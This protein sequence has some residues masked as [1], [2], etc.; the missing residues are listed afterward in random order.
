[1]SDIIFVSGGSRSG[2]SEFA[3]K[4]VGEFGESIL[5][6]ATGVNT[7]SEMNERIL[8]HKNRRPK[9]WI[10]MEAYK[11]L[12]I[13][14]GKLENAFDATL[15]DCV[16][17]MVT[18]ILFE[19]G[20][21]NEDYCCDELKLAEIVI[22]EF[23]KIVKFHIGEQKHLVLVTSE[24]GLGIIPEGKINRRFRDVLGRVNQYL[25]KRSNLA[26]FVVAGLPM[27]LK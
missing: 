13:E 8:K 19:L 4:L 21:F 24:I 20:A 9:T 10:T 3:E 23:E 17:V 26:Y 12:D 18:N 15:V 14:L 11:E 22:S 25:A 1:M 2:K 27:K 5:Y 6:I 7:D 16:A